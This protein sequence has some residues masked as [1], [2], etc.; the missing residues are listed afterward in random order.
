MA[1]SLAAVVGATAANAAD[2]AT[3]TATKPLLML[4]LLMPLLA[5]AAAECLWLLLELPVLLATCLALVSYTALGQSAS[6]SS[7]RPLSQDCASPPAARGRSAEVR[8]LLF[9]LRPIGKIS[10]TAATDCC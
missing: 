7:S 2:A 8:L 9:L 6:F 4:P 5:A 10:I 3:D 1:V